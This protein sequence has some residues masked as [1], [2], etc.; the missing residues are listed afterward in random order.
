MNRLL[1]YVLLREAARK[2]AR[3]DK[4]QQPPPQPQDDDQDRRDR[5]DALVRSWQ[6]LI[7]DL[8]QANLRLVR[9]LRPL[10]AQEWPDRYPAGGGYR[11]LRKPLPE[12]E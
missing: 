12:D 9:R 11:I 3:K 7:A 5:Y 2:R 6:T 10:R 8:P 4:A 1:A